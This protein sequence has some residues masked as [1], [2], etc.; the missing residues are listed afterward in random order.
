M[1]YR[2]DIDGLRAIAVLSVIVFHSGIA[3]LSGGFIGVDVFFVISGYLI[4]TLIYSEIKNGKFTFTNFYKRRAAR[5]LPALCITLSMVLIFGFIF[6]NN[7][8]F[9]NLGKEIF[10][11]SFGAANILFSQGLNYF[12]NDDAYRPLI[13]LWSLGVEEQFYIV[14]PIL[15]L[16]VSRFSVNTLLVIA[17]SFLVG[18][19]SLSIYSVELAQTKGYFLL[20]YRAF[21]LLVGATTSIIIH[22]KG[23]PNFNSVTK[24]CLSFLGIFLI[25]VPM[26]ALDKESNFPGLNA[27]WPC[28]GTAII[29]AI[30][31]NGVIT[32]I[33]SHR[34][35]VR[36]GLISYPLYLYHQ[37]FISFFKYFQFQLSP[38]LTLV[39]VLLLSLPLSWFT[40]RYVESPIRKQVHI[41]GAKKIPLPIWGLLSSIPFFA[42]IG[43]TI[44]KNGGLEDRFRLL[45]PFAFEISKASATTFHDNFERGYNVNSS[46][47]GRALF[48]GDSVLQHYI[49]PMASALDIQKDEIDTVTRGGCVLLK[50]VQFIDQFSDISCSDIRNSLYKSKK[51]YDYV[52]ISQA[53]GSYLSSVTNFPEKTAGYDKWVPFLNATIE[54]FSRFTNKII[55][56]GEHVSV[57]GTLYLQPSITIDKESYVSRLDELSI[58][59]V[60]E[61]KDSI[62]FFERYS[63]GKKIDVVNPYNIFCQ[64]D[65]VTSNGTWSYFID[66]QHLSVASTKFVTNKLKSLIKNIP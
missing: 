52:V 51:T 21:E 30:P 39:T 3:A 26:F 65:C 59:N 9:D 22:N 61:L 31:S 49:L 28:I 43:V 36:V 20:Q 48:V 41:K 8:A 35:L 2:R 29:I 25:F 57:D 7:S 23:L 60:D 12:A 40:Y 53:W 46:D 38:F 13:H 45:N 16:L 56:I 44:A 17:I 6:Y 42:I 15:L 32:R 64:K 4:T 37:P 27:L 34:V 62:D 63:T 47:H 14:W 50:D 1:N 58:I 18:S 10:F 66:G 33:L 11:S 54:H 24:R 55:I 5:L 19:L